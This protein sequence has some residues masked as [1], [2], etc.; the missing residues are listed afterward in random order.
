MVVGLSMIQFKGRFVGVPDVY[1]AR[2]VAEL[3]AMGKLEAQGDLRRMRFNEVR[4]S[5]R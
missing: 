4:I 1:Y 3:V 5:E 2:R